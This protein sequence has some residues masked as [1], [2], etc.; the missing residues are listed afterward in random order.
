MSEDGAHYILIKGLSRINKPAQTLGVIPEAVDVSPLSERLSARGRSPVIAS[1]TSD[2]PRDMESSYSG[3]SSTEKPPQLG[4]SQEGVKDPEDCHGYCTP[5][6]V[7]NVRVV[8]VKDSAALPNNGGINSDTSDVRLK[9][10]DME[11]KQ[12]KINEI[13]FDFQ[14]GTTIVLSEED[15]MESVNDTSVLHVDPEKL[16]PVKRVTESSNE[17]SLELSD[18]AKD[19]GGSSQ[20][21]WQQGDTEESSVSMADIEETQALSQQNSVTQDGDKE[22]CIIVRH[23]D[24]E[25]EQTSEDDSGRVI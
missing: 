23:K 19:A 7:N 14:H 2:E 6:E 10:D 1:S 13:A 4:G 16:T 8:E 18:E 12:S 9:N 20:N 17:H 3:R 5:L 25:M 24:G 22:E 15:S 21:V 11:P